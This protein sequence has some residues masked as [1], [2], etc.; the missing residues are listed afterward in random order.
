MRRLRDLGKQLRASLGSLSLEP[1]CLN[2][3]RLGPKLWFQQL[4]ERQVVAITS[5]FSSGFAA[6]IFQGTVRTLI[7]Q[8]TDY[9]LMP[10]ASG[11][12]EQREI[13]FQTCIHRLFG[14]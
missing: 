10:I 5:H 11:P 7:K 14:A 8:E 9:R 6:I 4:G 3:I 12:H 2:P 1:G 13:V